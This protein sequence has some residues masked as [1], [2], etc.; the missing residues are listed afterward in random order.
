M[1]LRS[2]ALLA[3]LSLCLTACSSAP[4]APE[5]APAGAPTLKVMTFNVNFGVAGDPST[6]E[7]IRAE[8]AELV[9]LQE[10]T[11]A[12]EQ[13][14][15]E[16]LAEEYPH[17]KFHHADALAGGLAVLSTR[18]VEIIETIPSPAGWFPAWRLEA[19]T[20]LGTIQLLNLHLRPPISDDGSWIK[21][22]FTTDAIRQ[23]ELT[24]YMARLKPDLPTIVAGDFNED[25]SGDVVARL[26]ADGLESALEEFRPG[27]HTW[28]WELPVGSVGHQ[29]D[30]IAYQ[31]TALRPL[32]AHVRRAGRSDHFPV[33]TTFVRAR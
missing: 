6:I 12:W 16:A 9:L 20:A 8:G 26:R 18:P 29:L 27:E 13:A 32:G 1:P 14:L 22:Y 21:G 23:A 19:E 2:L 15:R 10:T 3:A 30:H 4:R 24:R 7:A 5:A 33:V 28:R 17:M 25:A 11:P 31:K